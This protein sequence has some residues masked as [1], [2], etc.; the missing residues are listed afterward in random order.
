MP[1]SG[2]YNLQQPSYLLCFLLGFL[3]LQI[4]KG[5][6][7]VESMESKAGVQRC[8]RLSC[9]RE[10]RMAFGGVSYQSRNT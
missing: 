4:L 7:V 6:F 2:Q 1:V 3:F 10:L 8:A 9:R 5:T